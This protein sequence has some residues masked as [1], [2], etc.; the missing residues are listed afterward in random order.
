M[1]NDLNGQRDLNETLVEETYVFRLGVISK[2]AISDL[3]DYF[4]SNGLE[5]P[6]ASGIDLYRAITNDS[7]EIKS[8]FENYNFTE[9]DKA[10]LNDELALLTDSNVHRSNLKKLLSTIATDCDGESIKTMLINLDYPYEK[11]TG[12]SAKNAEI[13]VME[14]LEK[15]NSKFE[16]KEMKIHGYK[17]MREGLMVYY[18][19]NGVYHSCRALTSEERQ[20]E[21]QF[22]ENN[23]E[24]E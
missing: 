24:N 9:Q 12:K 22:V 20:L 14:I 18:D 1:K 23:D 5:M 15:R 17:N 19:E 3:E 10:D 21:L 8:C 7:V 13:R 2:V 4:Q 6:L 16:I 11:I